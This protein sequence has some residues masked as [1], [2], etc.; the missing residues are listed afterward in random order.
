[1]ATPTNEIVSG[2]A[3]IKLTDV[4]LNGFDAGVTCGFYM[5]GL[6][7][8]IGFGLS[9][10]TADGSQPTLALVKSLDWSSVKKACHD[11]IESLEWLRSVA[12]IPEGETIPLMVGDVKN[13]DYSGPYS[14]DPFVS[15]YLVK[16]IPTE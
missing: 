4:S 3:V 11:H 1:M 14:E 2:D 13:V 5:S 10:S 15:Y 12:Y 8:T 7:Y 9:V 6:S 16:G